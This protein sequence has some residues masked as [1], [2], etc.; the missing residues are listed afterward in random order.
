MRTP[1]AV[2]AAAAAACAGVLLGTAGCGLVHPAPSSMWEIRVRAQRASA[3]VLVVDPASAGNTAA[4]IATLTSTSRVGE[5]LIVIDDRTG[6]VLASST[7]PTAPP[8]TISLRRPVLPEHPTPFQRARYLRAR[9]AFRATVRAARSSLRRRQRR[10]LAAWVASAVGA[11]RHA[12]ARSMPGQ[13]RSLTWAVRTG[14]ADLWTLQHA[15]VDLGQREVVA[16]LGA[17][18]S[19]AKTDKGLPAGQ[20]GLIGLQGVTVVVPDFPADVRDQVA[21]QSELL[22]AGASRVVLLTPA[23]I[24][25]LP[26][27]VGQGLDGSITDTLGHVLF[28]TGQFRLR[29]AALPA[30]RHLLR[31]LTVNYPRANVVIT[32]YTDDLPATGGN[33][34]LSRER[35]EAVQAWLVEHGVTAG[36]LEAIG[37][38]DTDPVAPNSPVGQP[39]DRRVVVIIDPI[40]ASPSH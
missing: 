30:M 32:G 6:A 19:T 36:R 12:L 15:G 26:V 23:S 35:A 39:L 31:L 24:D 37:L 34:L 17:D 14:A 20:N 29:S 16:I 7:A 38:G 22:Q 13:P 18:P 3:L 28:K 4:A 21:W 25:Q 2:A 10:V 40:T 5:H 27:A 33:L 9:G 11:I 1:S 8:M